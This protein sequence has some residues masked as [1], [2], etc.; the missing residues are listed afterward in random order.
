MPCSQIFTT[1]PTDRGMCC[2]FNI[3]KAEK[4]FANGIFTETIVEMQKRDRKLAFERHEKIPFEPGDDFPQPRAGK[5]K[6]E[7]IVFKAKNLTRIGAQ[8]VALCF[9]YLKL[10]QI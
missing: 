6:A 4:L 5:S 7:F 2:S 1:M 10:T 9:H 8:R 3:Q